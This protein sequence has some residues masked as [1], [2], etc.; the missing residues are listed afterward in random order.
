M[1]LIKFYR[2]NISKVTDR[3]KICNRHSLHTTAETVKFRCRSHSRLQ[4]F[5]NFR[6]NY[7]AA[8]KHHC[9]CSCCS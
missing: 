7:T 8:D 2:Q 6:F 1:C 4:T 3:Y 9:D 5:S